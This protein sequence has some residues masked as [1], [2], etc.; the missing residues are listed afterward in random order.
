VG[1]AMAGWTESREF[2]VD[3]F[4]KL[5][6]LQPLSR[7]GRRPAHPMAIVRQ[8][9]RAML[10]ETAVLG[11]RGEVRQGITMNYFAIPMPRAAK[12]CIHRSCLE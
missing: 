2:A 12:T 4:M 5:T 8:E 7:K 11:A 10:I 3:T 1:G 9:I 6:V